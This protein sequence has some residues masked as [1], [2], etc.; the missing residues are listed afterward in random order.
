ML[1]ANAF[2]SSVAAQAQPAAQPSANDSAVMNLCNL[3]AL[4]INN[5]EGEKTPEKIQAAIASVQAKLNGQ[6]KAEIVKDLL[7]TANL[8]AAAANSKNYDA[9]FNGLLATIKLKVVPHLYALGLKYIKDNVNGVS[10]EDQ[11]IKLYGYIFTFATEYLLDLV[12]S[13]K[14]TIMN[15]PRAIREN[16]SHAYTAIAKRTP[17]LYFSFRRAKPAAAAADGSRKRTAE[18]RE[19]PDGSPDAKV[20]AKEKSVLDLRPS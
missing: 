8:P 19:E 18:Q 11:I 5:I 16:G 20:A 7:T 4:E 1:A 14:D 9:I 3:I 2:P 17:N 13:N 12:K 6:A 15:L 10:D